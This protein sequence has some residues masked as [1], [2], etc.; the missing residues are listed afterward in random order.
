MADPY[1]SQF[2]RPGPQL[3]AID[4]SMNRLTQN[5]QAIYYILYQLGSFAHR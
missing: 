3:T 1:G 5:T 4:W 2:S